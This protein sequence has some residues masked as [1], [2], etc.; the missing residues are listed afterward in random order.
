M[1][2]WLSEKLESQYPSFGRKDYK[3]WLENKKLLPL[4]DGLDEVK[5]SQQ[6]S[7]VQAINHWLPEGTSPPYLVVC[8]RRKEYETVIRGHWSE[9]TTDQ[10]EELWLQ[11][12]GAILLQPLTDEQIQAYLTAANQPKLWQIIEQDLELLELIR[13]PLFLQILGF[14]TSQ[15]QFSIQDWR[16]LFSTETRLQY[17]FNAYWDAAME[18]ELAS[19][20]M[21]RQ[22]IKSQSYG[23]RKLPKK[24]ET[25]AWLI[26]LA[27]QLQRESPTEFLIENLQPSW[28]ATNYSQPLYRFIARLVIYLMCSLSLGSI[29]EL[30]DRPYLASLISIMPVGYCVL[31]AF[32][33]LSSSLG[34]PYFLFGGI[35]LGLAYVHFIVPSWA[36]GVILVGLLISLIANRRN[37]LLLGGTL[38]G[39]VLLG[40]FT[41]VHFIVPSWLLGVILVGLL[42]DLIVN[43]RDWEHLT[44]L[45]ENSI[46]VGSA[47]SQHL[48]HIFS[49]PLCPRNLNAAVNLL[50]G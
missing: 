14:I 41:Y 2:N 37:C 48:R 43:R 12:G 18:R 1:T 29:L 20:Q 23:K 19:S 46:D 50:N 24:G 21:R 9:E 35:L 34:R 6:E 38:L 5:P 8:C 40:L 39:G 49:V 28:L 13:T 33:I 36:L 47:L 10:R 44:L 7:C 26:F 3:Q 30:I 32:V 25:Q 22:G 16:T 4:L 31:I 11:M 17:L 42:I 27:Q 45:R 15:D